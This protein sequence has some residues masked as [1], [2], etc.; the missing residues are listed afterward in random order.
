M[1]SKKLFTNRR[2]IIIIATICCILWGSSYPSIKTG[3]SMF[4][5]IKEDIPSKLL[6]A[7]YRFLIAG[8]LVLLWAIISRKNIFK[9]NKK[10][11]FQISILGLF[12]TGLQYMLFYI[13]LAYTT[14][15]KG[16]IINGTVA[17][18]SVIIAH[19]LYK[20]DKLNKAKILGC[21]LGLVGIIAINIS[22]DFSF[23][24]S[25]KGEG[26]VLISALMLSVGPMYGKK[27][28]ETV[29]P[30]LVTGYQ[31][32]IGG[33]ALVIAGYAFGGKLTNFTAGSTSILIYL[34][35]LSSLAFTL[36]A[37]LMKYNKVSTIAVFNSLVPIFGTVLSA[38]FLNENLWKIQN[39]I[40]LICVCTG[41]WL[42]Y[43]E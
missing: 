20:N 13:G 32:S 22:P 1:D 5:I 33:L 12:Q 24:F 9:F 41:I 29:D 17:F 2:S 6:F 16:S 21:L 39:G 23:I 35:V 27:I 3:Y 28:T 18:F 37:A 19:F 38:I 10:E 4:N 42:V 31:L 26:F 40:G 8:L 14:G 25:F 36:W 7:G 30:V 15:T 34:A 43:K 11:F